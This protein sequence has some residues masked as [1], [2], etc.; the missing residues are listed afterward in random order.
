MLGKY[1]GSV[2]L[3]IRPHSV[4]KCSDRMGSRPESS[5]MHQF[6]NHRSTPTQSNP[7]ILQGPASWVIAMLGF[8]PPDDP[9][10]FVEE[11]LFTVGGIRQFRCQILS[12][13]MKLL[14]H[15]RSPFRTI[16]HIVN[17]TA[18][19][20]VFP[21]AAFTRIAPELCAAILCK[22]S[23]SSSEIPERSKRLPTGLSLKRVA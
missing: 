10:I 22:K 20:N 7:A 9:N 14:V 11:D 15:F 3:K 4:T 13:E 8:Q 16:R 5:D 1:C 6:Y 17:D 2:L 18:V 19:R 21:R 12:C 23:R